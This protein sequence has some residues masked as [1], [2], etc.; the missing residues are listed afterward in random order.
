MD[1]TPIKRAIGD[2]WFA[3]AQ[4]H[5][6]LVKA[7]D[8]P[9]CDGDP[10]ADACRLDP[11]PAEHCAFETVTVRDGRKNLAGIYNLQDRFFFLCRRHFAKGIAAHSIVYH[12]PCTKRMRVASSPPEGMMTTMA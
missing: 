9:V 2:A 4:P 10:M 1:R 7:E 11:F 6:H 12:I 8:F 5:I 3:E